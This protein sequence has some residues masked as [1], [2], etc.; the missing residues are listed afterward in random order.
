[1]VFEFDNKITIIPV[2]TN[3]FINKIDASLTDRAKFVILSLP[4][5]LQM[6]QRTNF[7]TILTILTFTA[8]AQ[9][10]F[11]LVNFASGFSS[12]VDIASAGDDRLFIVERQGYIRIVELDGT[13]LPDDFLDINTQIE[14]GY[15]EQ[16]LLGLAFHP[17]YADNGYFYVNYTDEDGNTVVSRFTVSAINP[18]I[19]DPAT[20]LIIYTADQPFTNH[21][22]GCI[23]FGA[24]GY[25]YIGLGDGGSGGDPGNR[26]QNPENKLG[27]M[28]R[29]D[30]DGGTPFAIPTDN[31]FALATDTLPE[32]WAIG[33]RNPWRFS[34]D[35]LNGN[36]WI[37]DVG[38]NLQEEVN[39]ELAGDGGHNYGWRCYEGFDEFNDT[40]CDDDSTYAFPILQYPHNYS[41]GGFSVTGGFV[42]RGT[43]FPGMYGFYMFA[44]YVSGNWWWVNADAGAPYYYERVDDVKT[45][46][47]CFGE[48]LNGE[49]YCADLNTGI[50][51]H[52]TDACGDYAIN[53]T[54][55]DYICGVTDGTATVI[56]SA[57]EAPY[58]IEWSTGATTE[59][60]TDLVTGMYTVSVTDNAGC[61]RTAVVTI[62]ETINFFV[63]I[64]LD[65]YTLTAD[66]GVS[67]QWY[68][69]GAAIPDA[70]NATFEIMAPGEYY[71][72]ATDANG[73]TAA[74]ETVVFYDNINTFIA[75]LIEVA[76]NPVDETLFVQLNSGNMNGAN[77]RIVNVTGQI[78]FET[79]LLQTNAASLITIDTQNWAT[80]MYVIALYDG[81]NNLMQQITIAKN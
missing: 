75:P 23:K 78:I 60:A 65:G 22:G 74:S 51:Y 55:T 44:D 73:C 14:A 19:A 59:T 18:N 32:I 39:V 6:N 67:W 61:E 68:V 27:K 41:T 37:G 38:Q 28:H 1:M 42:Y 21:N 31:P 2:Y 34:F 9:P 25:L 40:G 54:T 11:D 4:K 49:I 64:V 45:D 13:V 33:Y 20:E 24:D 62:N 30:V 15:Q 70:T 36:M 53:T 16:G 17:N 10:A 29:I 7:L 57:G 26:A 48:D 72:I 79:D 80:G 81:S 56:I 12:P 50:I 58:N 69:D 77:M 5:I 8:S 76:P 35:K 46:I 66:A 71:V 52:V 63:N 43:A 3:K 47:S